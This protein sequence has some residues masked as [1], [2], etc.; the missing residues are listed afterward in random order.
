MLQ[1][2]GRVGD[3]RRGERNRQANPYGRHLLV[4]HS[5]QSVLWPWLGV[6]QAGTTGAY[7]TAFSALLLSMAGRDRTS[8]GSLVHTPQDLLAPASGPFATFVLRVR[9]GAGRCAQ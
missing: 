6:S 1:R 5:G 7:M 4:L 8:P 9:P 2:I 3:Q